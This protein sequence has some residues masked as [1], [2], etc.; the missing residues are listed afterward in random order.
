[1]RSKILNRENIVM[2]THY[3]SNVYSFLIRRKYPTNFLMRVSGDECGWNLNPFDKGN[4][5]LHIWMEKIDPESPLPIRVARH[6]DSSGH[7]PDGDF[8][9]FASLMYGKTGDDLLEQINKDMN[10]K[11]IS[12]NAP[13]TLFQKDRLD[14][15]VFSFFKCPITNKMPYRQITV[16]DAYRVIAGYYYRRRTEELRAIR[17]PR[18]ARIFKANKFDYVTFS[19]TFSTRREQNLLEHSRLLCLDFDHVKFLEPLFKDLSMDDNFDTQLLFRSPSGDG[20]KWVIHIDLT[21][22]SHKDWFEGVASYISQ[23]Y[24]VEVDRSGKDVCRACFLPYDP[25]AYVAPEILNAQ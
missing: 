22:A 12:K 4:P 15:P 23:T 16:L 5:S 10:L 7:I 3:G 21:L 8:L 2:S 13:G 6:H 9:D 11:L 17:D 1:M 24:H 20:L 18:Q 14:L 19:G 25:K